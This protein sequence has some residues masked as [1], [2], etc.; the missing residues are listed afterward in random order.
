VK[1]SNEFSVDAPLQRTWEVLSD[2]ERVA[3]CLPGAAIEP[4]GE[5]GSYR[6][7]LK[8]R[9]G[10]VAI[11]YE[12][13]VRLNDSDELAHVLGYEASAHESRGPGT[14]AAQIHA[15]LRPAPDG[16]T[17]VRVETELDVT[18]R[19]AQFGRGM[20]ES[21]AGRMLGRFAA[22]L[23]ELIESG[24]S[25]ESEPAPTAGRLAGIGTPPA[26]ASDADPAAARSS[27]GPWR[28]VPGSVVGAAGLATAVAALGFTWQ[29]AR[30]RRPRL[31]VTLRVRLR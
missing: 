24:P 23:Q 19:A 26:A 20:V 3:G 4:V 10:P 15:H 14:A 8:L 11:G 12:G 18:G 27:P 9:V 16:G 13:T 30:R 29:A 6:G 31:Q 21:V 17:H 2:V 25:A 28:P 22:Q 7:A 5:D 1:L